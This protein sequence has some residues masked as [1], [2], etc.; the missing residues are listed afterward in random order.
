MRLEEFLMNLKYQ[1]QRLEILQAGTV[2][3]TISDKR[4]KQIIEVYTLNK[5]I[6]IN[7]TKDFKLFGFNVYTSRY[8]NNNEF[9]VG[10]KY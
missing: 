2:C 3:V 5:G 1:L 9:I 10:F 7:Q 6:K 8:M 4:A